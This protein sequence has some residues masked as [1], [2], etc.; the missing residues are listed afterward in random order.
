[1]L[2]IFVSSNEGSYFIQESR[3]L[4]E[5]KRYNQRRQLSLIKSMSPLTLVIVESHRYFRGLLV[6]FP[7]YINQIQ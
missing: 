2:V 5:L 1:M 6:Q 4:L 7:C 3:T